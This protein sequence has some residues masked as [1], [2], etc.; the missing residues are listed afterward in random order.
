MSHGSARPL[1]W[2][3]AIANGWPL[4]VG[5][6]RI[7]GPGG[8]DPTMLGDNLYG[9]WDSSLPNSIGLD[10]VN[11]TNV[12][13]W[14]DVKGNLVVSQA[15]PALQPL[16]ARDSRGMPA[17]SFDGIGTFLSVNATGLLPTGAA[18]CEIWVL[19]NQKLLGTV[20][21][22]GRY[23]FNY[24]SAGSSINVRG[25][26]RTVVSTVSQATFDCGNGTTNN[27]IS[28]PN[29]PFDGITVTHATTNGVNSFLQINGVG[30]VTS[31]LGPPASS[32]VRTVFGASYALNAGYWSGDIY[33]V[34][35][36]NILSATDSAIMLAYLKTTGGVA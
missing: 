8:W 20:D 6:S 10:P 29:P 14:K 23:A 21:T 28:V 35:V 30:T 11:T 13:S 22:T 24:G 36:T 33:K 32:P 15:N 2:Q 5:S 26:R 3:Q 17:V 18:P 34:I 19:S 31:A 7:F 27:A 4:G 9:Y 12:I 16:L 1:L 25:I